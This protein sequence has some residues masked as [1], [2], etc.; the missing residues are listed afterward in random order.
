MKAQSILAA[1]AIVAITAATI[2]T[3]HSHK[4]LVRPHKVNYVRWL[5]KGQRFKPSKNIVP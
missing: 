1:F 5:G 2:L 4:E 3:I